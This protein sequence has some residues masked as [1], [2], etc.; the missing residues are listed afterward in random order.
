MPEIARLAGHG[1]DRVAAIGP[2]GV[3]VQVAA[4][5]R[6]QRVARFGTGLGRV[7]EQILEVLRRLAAQRLG[8]HGRGLLADVG[9]VGEATGVGEPLQLFGRNARDR[10]GRAL[11]RLLAIRGRAPAHQEL[12]DALEC[13]DRRHA[14]EGTLPATFEAG[15]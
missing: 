9:N 7:G 6:A 11:E 8:D 5:L 15:D 2:I 12:R 14:P 10:R 3:R 1:C 4:E 13:L